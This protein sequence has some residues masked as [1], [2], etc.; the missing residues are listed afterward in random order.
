[1]ALKHLV[2]VLLL[3]AISGCASVDV[4]QS[5]APAPIQKNSTFADARALA[6]QQATLPADARA[7]NAARIEA[8]LAQLD[9]ASLSRG[10]GE[11]PTG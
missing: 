9:D 4:Q 7:A 8:L 10:A 1:M 5:T 3:A 11:L 6:S 2:F